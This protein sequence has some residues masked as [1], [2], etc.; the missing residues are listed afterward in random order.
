M[1][2]S[3]RPRT[4]G[5]QIA[6]WSCAATA[7]LG[8]RAGVQPATHAALEMPALSAHAPREAAYD[9]QRYRLDIELLPDARRIQGTCR[10]LVWPRATALASLDFDLDDLDVSAVRDDH[11]RALAF[12]R[13]PGTVR[14]T[15]AEPLQPG[16]CTEVA[17]DYGGKPRKGLYF[18]AERDGVPTQVFTQGECEDSRG[19]FPC[20]DAPSD[21]AS[22][23]LRVTMPARW[24][25]V[26]AGERIERT[27]REGRATELW[28]M[29]TPHPPYL[30]TLVAGDFTVKT[31][32]WEGT[33][34]VY[35]A[36]PRLAHEVEADL[37]RTGDVLA[38]FSQVT[39][40][41]YPYPKYAQACVEDFP[42]G[43]MENI[44]ATTL[45][46]T[47]LVDGKAR[48]DAQQTDL[49][50]HEAA[51]QW[52]GDLL[53]CRDWSH[54]WL[55][56]GFATYC[57]ALFTEHDLGADEFRFRMRGM[58]DGYV[59]ADVGKNR[60]P[61]VFDVYRRPMDLFFSG[62]VYGGGAVRLHLLRFVVGDDAFF[63][64]IRTYVQRNAGRSVVTDD[65]RRAMEEASN[66]DLAGFFRD[67]F[68]S[69]G[70]PEF[71]SGWRYDER[72]QILIVSV[73][74]VQDVVGGTPAA[75]RIPVELGI[76]DSKGL[77]LARV[78]IERRRELFEIP[79][80]EKPV[81]VRF[82]ERGWIPKRL[83]ERKPT[84]EWLAIATSDDDVNGR[85]DAVKVL[86]GI[87]A[88]PSATE[89]RE[90][91]LA[92]LLERLAKDASGAVR[93]DAAS[94][95]ATVRDASARS[96]LMQAAAGDA[97][98]RV[99]V[100]AFAALRG[101]GADAE[102]AAF[103]LR[104]Y[105]KAFSWDSAAAA[106]S[107]YATARPQG[108]FE[109]IVEQLAVE[110]PRDALRARLLPLLDGRGN[111]RALAVATRIALDAHADEGGRAAAAREV[112]V[113]G[114]GN[115]QAR[116]DLETLLDSAPWRVRRET[117]GALAELKDP[118]AADA[119]RA[120]YGRTALVPELRAIEAALEKLRGE[121]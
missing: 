88:K 111:G 55:N 73:S 36:E 5:I 112:G 63:R 43:G 46:D 57:A 93:A 118:A 21:R 20:F 44:S 54:V 4:L 92:A 113:L 74:Q 68:E 14:I 18:F 33:P 102:L 116:H 37:G 117:I 72:R 76:R 38:F 79:A 65:F 64:G 108:A 81:F 99:R 85:R 50:A 62:H 49:V 96:A 47:C 24:S 61:M 45:T 19:W 51:H 95:L 29:T 89:S 42:Y 78:A 80:P 52:F 70:F 67:W 22:S 109:W 119:L 121:G 94:G 48:R 115:P 3:I 10:V 90:A 75:F 53:T 104:E 110:S 6:A 17:I 98:A 87:L 105:Q 40:R 12:A 120:R 28:R 114:R 35:L 71:E 77:R 30:T 9:V 23:E 107:L 83:D 11:G 39:G 86:A 32:S 84:E 97:E 59:A 26:A 106:A 69:P 8:C 66:Q 82:D 60:R 34:L 100:A 13:S 2:T 16:D 56:E 7:V 58:Q 1:T 101:F 15:L 91:P 27:E 31:G 25:A 103:A 41:R